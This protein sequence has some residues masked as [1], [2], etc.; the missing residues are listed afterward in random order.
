[1]KSVVIAQRRGAVS[2]LLSML[3]IASMLF[4][5]NNT[6]SDSGAPAALPVAGKLLLN[7]VTIVST[8]DGRLT[9]NMSILMERGRIERIAPVGSLTDASA[10][11]I[12]A[13]GK[14]VV[15]GYVDM[16]VH[17]LGHADLPAN[18]KLMLANGI[19]GFR[20]M[21]GSD[22]LL[23]QQRSGT[24]PISLDAPALLALPGPLLTPFNARNT[25]DATVTVEEQHSAGADF[26]KIG[27]VT[28][29]AFF[30]ALAT[31]KRLG[32]PVVGHV[33]AQVDVVA[34]SQAGMHSIEHL[35]PDSGVLVACSSE[36]AA[37]RR[38][39][40]TLPAPLKGPPFKIPFAD[41][42]VTYL[43][44]DRIINPAA[45]E[46]EEQ[47]ALLRRTIDSFSEGKCRQV[48]AQFV[49]N[50]TWQVPTLIRI[51]S[52]QL[53]FEA[54]FEHDPNL[55]YVSAESVASWKK[56]TRKYSEHLSA[57]AKQTL[58]DGYA[59]DLKLVELLDA[60][61][62]RMLTGSDVTG[63]GWLVPGFSLHQEFDQLE[64]A[65]LAPLRVLQMTTIN[66]AEFLG[67]ADDLGSVEPGRAADLVVL[68]ANPLESV[69]NLH[70][71]HAVVRAGFYRDRRYLETLKSS[72]AAAPGDN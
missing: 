1:M 71:I 40:A 6:G 57:D 2:R 18:L 50:R 12:D 15:P 51:R 48:A 31:G 22:K 34:A 29:D 44:K 36:E 52:S 10:E 62:V 16:H 30:A 41:A 21:Q 20:Q 60:A 45:G 13:A 43:I 59:L 58:R 28:P 64:Q 70:R 37:L 65:G 68:D 39:I 5:C 11:T 54:E 4:G 72:V 56:V 32:I 69:Q 55:G 9:P 67:R 47:L 25:L 26:I 66:A 14:F 19:T 3:V 46:S 27:L 49:A 61:G 35:G 17:V 8:V 38:Q 33:P 24:L 63:A 23:E 42:I 53:A 7:G